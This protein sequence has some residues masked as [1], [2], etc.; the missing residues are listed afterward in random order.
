MGHGDVPASRIRREW[1][2]SSGSWPALPRVSGVERG[3]CL[4][5]CAKNPLIADEGG[6]AEV[7]EFRTNRVLRR[8]DRE[9]DVAMLKLLGEL[10]QGLA[11]GKVNVVDG[12]G[13]QHNPRRL[14]G[15]S[16]MR[17]T[18]S[19]SREALA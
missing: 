11:A 4:V 19:V 10:D 17:S 14:L 6:Q 3:D 2:T 15:T 9:N 13:E 1:L 7:V 16:T 12:V 18:S 8:G 5:K